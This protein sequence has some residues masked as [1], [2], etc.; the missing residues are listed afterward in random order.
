MNEKQHYTREQLNHFSNKVLQ[1]AL[2]VHSNLGPGLL[3]KTYEACL[4]YELD[5]MGLDSSS[6]VE[7]PVHYG[8]IDIP[9]GY[10]VDL[11]VQNCILV[12]LKATERI[13]P[14]HEAQLLTYL[15]ISKTRL[16]LLINFNVRRLRD[17]IKRIVK[18]F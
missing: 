4:I 7:L 8:D 17:G 12:E 16:G 1:A 10:R 6:Q 2:T 13:T 14:L 18:N 11:I 3:E 5:K 15:K 9:L